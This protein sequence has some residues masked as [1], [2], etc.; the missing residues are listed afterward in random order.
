MRDLKIAHVILRDL[1]IAH[2]ISVRRHL[3]S[4]RKKEIAVL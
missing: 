4:P 3:I 1:K 2:V